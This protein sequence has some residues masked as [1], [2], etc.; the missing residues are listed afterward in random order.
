MT[1]QNNVLLI[2]KNGIATEKNHLSEIVVNEKS[3][4]ETNKIEI[5]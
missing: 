3:K 2:T 1:V 4:N 5:L